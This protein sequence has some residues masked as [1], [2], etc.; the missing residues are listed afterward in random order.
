VELRF[1]NVRDAG[2][3]EKSLKDVENEFKV[4][5]TKCRRVVTIMGGDGSLGTTIKALRKSEII[6]DAMHHGKLFFIVLPYGTG[7]DGA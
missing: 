6:D 2:E 1:Y 5:D 3:R 7:N 4:K